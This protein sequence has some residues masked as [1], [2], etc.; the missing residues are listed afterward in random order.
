M[1]KLEER[2]PQPLTEIV[3]VQNWFE[4]LRRLAPSKK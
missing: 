4:E 2:K 3:L 1:V